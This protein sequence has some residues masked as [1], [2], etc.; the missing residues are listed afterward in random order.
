[1]NDHEKRL[2]EKFEKTFG[3]A[4]KDPRLFVRAVTHRS[5]LNQNGMS[6]S[7]SNER[8]EFLGDSVLGL[9]VNE[10]LFKKLPGGRE[11]DLT[12]IKS[13]LVSEAVLAQQAKRMG[14]G[15]YLLLGPGEED[16][17]GRE[18]PSILSDAFEALVGALYVDSGIAQARAFVWNWLL[19]SA[20]EIVGTH[21]FENYKS[22]LQ[23][24]VQSEYH[25][26]PRYRVCAEKGPDHCKVFSVEV[27]VDKQV[28]GKGRGKNK[29]QAE[30]EAAKAALAF[31]SRRELKR[32]RRRG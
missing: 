8:L 2:F 21:A 3:I 7:D 10:H 22:A 1:M 6:R 30:Q 29:K 18:R 25:A 13:L 16:S 9:L 23:E 31:L 32:G 27:L 24:R 28:L 5:Y 26:H 20:D 15:E 17:G 19:K 11:G 12:R 4:F 14:L